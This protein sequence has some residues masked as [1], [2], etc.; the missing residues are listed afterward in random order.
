MN[1]KLHAGINRGNAGAYYTQVGLE[2]GV[3]AATPQHLITMLFDGAELA[4]RTARLHME[5]GNQAAKGDAM[6]KALDIIN[7]GLLAALDRE[8]GGEVAARLAALYDY[9]GRLLLQATLRNDVRKLDEA[10]H[11]LTN[12]STAWRDLERPRQAMND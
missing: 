4:I 2:S 1:M 11:L 6:G 12:I 3:L 5:D 10:M 8:Q 9:I 7:Q